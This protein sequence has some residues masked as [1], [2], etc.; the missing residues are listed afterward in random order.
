[1]FSKSAKSEEAPTQ[2]GD[3]NSR[4]RRNGEHAELIR[5]C[6]RPGL[7]TI[8]WQDIISSIYLRSPAQRY[9]FEVTTQWRR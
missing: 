5:I 9:D 1:M 2:E 6:S 3:K 8:E 4:L 7:K